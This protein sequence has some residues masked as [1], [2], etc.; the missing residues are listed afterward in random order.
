MAQAS[1]SAVVSSDILMQHLDIDRVRLQMHDRKA[2]HATVAC[3]GGPY[4]ATTCSHKAAC[5][6]MHT[7]EY[8]CSKP[9]PH[10]RT[11]CIA[12]WY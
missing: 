6:N 2:M 12:L 4:H 10:A 7:D 9:R 3:G 11:N 5:A 8:S 1:A